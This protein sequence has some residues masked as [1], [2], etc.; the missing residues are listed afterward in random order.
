MLFDLDGT[1]VDSAPDLAASANRLRQ[2]RGL[3]PLPFA[4]LRDFCGA[5]ARGMLA[6]SLRLTPDAPCYEAERRAFLS[7]YE[8]HMFDK[9]AL[10]SGVRD[11]LH[12]IEEA[13]WRWGIV[14]NKSARFAAPICRLLGL[15]GT[16]CLISGSDIGKMKP[17]PDALLAGIEACAGRTEETVYIGDDRRD[18]LCAA[19][20]GVPFIAAGWGYVQGSIPVEEWGANAVARRPEE[21]PQY[22]QRLLN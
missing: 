5:G 7:H 15:S 19:N 16:S 9:A 17:L 20:A 18:R 1:L 11:M 21:I 3:A 10:F 8:A 4:S 13:G 22:V 2:M 12:N 14:T 6:T